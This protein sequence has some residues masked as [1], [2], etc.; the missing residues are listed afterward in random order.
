MK[1]FSAIFFILLLIGCAGESPKDKKASEFTRPENGKITQKQAGYYVNASSN[2]MNAIKKHEEDI[3]EFIKRYHL[4]DDLFELSDSVYCEEHP[5][6]TRTWNRLQKRW[7][8]DELK[9]YKLAGLNEENFNWIGG[10]LADTVN[11]DI[12]KWIQTELEKAAKE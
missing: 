7:K 12:Q 3:Q 10:A 1:C 11:K 2:L 5:E 6:V 8:N 9:C 4:K